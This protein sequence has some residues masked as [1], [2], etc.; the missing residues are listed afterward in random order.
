MC[1]SLRY[2][3]LH[4]WVFLAVAS[5]AQDAYFPKGE[6]DSDT[7]SE[8]RKQLWYSHALKI[9]E[10]PSLLKLSENSGAESYRFLWLRTFK[11]P[12][13]VRLDL[14]S[15]GTAVLTAKITDGEAGFPYTV[16]HL[17]ESFAHS[18]EPEKIRSFL[19]KVKQVNFWSLPS[20]LHDQTGTDGSQW[21]IEGVKDG[22]YHV[23]DR[24]SPANGGIRELGLLLVFDLAK[25]NIPKDEVY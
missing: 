9:L 19:S 23:V 1:T 11:H 3:V 10:E 5:I 13:A 8:K 12:V 7:Q 22:K 6:L 14:K 17:T 24:W 18:A 20:H 15:D 25:M 16:A 2:A 21:I 4:F